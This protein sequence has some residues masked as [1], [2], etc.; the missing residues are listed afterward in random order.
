VLD[1]SLDIHGSG[2]W[3]ESDGVFAWVVEAE[4]VVAVLASLELLAYEV[5]IRG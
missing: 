2:R 5:Y 4:D 1:Y 3:D